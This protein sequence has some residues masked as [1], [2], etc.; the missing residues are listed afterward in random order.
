MNAENSYS[1]QEISAIT[2]LPSST[3]RYYEELG[4]LQPVERASNGHR[5]YNDMD[6]RRINFIKKLRVIGMSLETM[7]EFLALYEGGSAT[8][9]ERR[10]ILLEHRQNVQAQVDELLEMLRFIDYK[11]G[12]YKEE[13]AQH[14]RE[15]YE[16]SPTG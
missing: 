15:N 16:I 10:E 2:D 3:L 6:L 5:R 9:K 13:E 7:G 11:I 12:L 14:E 1:I 4:L 8:A